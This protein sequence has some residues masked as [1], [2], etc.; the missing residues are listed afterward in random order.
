MTHSQDSTPSPKIQPQPQNT[1]AQSLALLAGAGA[2]FVPLA[3]RAK[4]S[5]EQGWQRKPIPI[6]AALEHLDAGG[7]IGVLGG[8]NGVYVADFDRDLADAL[9][10]QPAFADGA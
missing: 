8:H 1:P 3:Y 5:Y 9:A 4:K 2:G 10:F 7:N 6:D